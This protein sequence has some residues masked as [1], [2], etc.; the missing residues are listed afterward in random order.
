MQRWVQTWCV[1]DQDH[2]VFRKGH[3]LTSWALRKIQ[4]S[5]YAP[6]ECTAKRAN[7]ECNCIESRAVLRANSKAT[8]VILPKSAQHFFGA[9]PVHSMS[10]HLR[11]VTD[12]GAPANPKGFK[13]GVY[14]V[15]VN[16][17]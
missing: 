13:R 11:Q 9:D 12:L 4:H 15:D 2:G 17:T 5:A 1:E 7:T 16:Y 14:A 6:A 10:L 3:V 8:K